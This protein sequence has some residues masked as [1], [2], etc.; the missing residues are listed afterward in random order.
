MFFN[1]Q[2]FMDGTPLVLFSGLDWHKEREEVPA[3]SCPS[4]LRPL[5]GSGLTP[6]PT[7]KKIPES[8]LGLT[9][10]SV[11]SLAGSVFTCLTVALGFYRLWI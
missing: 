8:D 4:S 9:A 1:K 10:L 3:V 2:C 6:G 5:T 11:V 7:Q